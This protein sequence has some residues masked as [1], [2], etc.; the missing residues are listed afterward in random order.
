MK[1]SVITVCRNSEKTIEETIKS[2]IKQTYNDI[3]YIIVDGASSDNTL[4]LVE[5]YRDKVS[6][7]IS[8]SDNGVYNAMNKGIKA[9]TGGFVVFSER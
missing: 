7:F 8:E 4:E 2:I 1:V 3:E 5:K 9:A 6:V